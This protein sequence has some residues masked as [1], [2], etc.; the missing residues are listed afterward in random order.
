MGHLCQRAA[1]YAR[2]IRNG[3]WIIDDNLIDDY[4]RDLPRAYELEV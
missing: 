2:A 4:I 1:F 3:V